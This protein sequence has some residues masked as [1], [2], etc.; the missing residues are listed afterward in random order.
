MDDSKLGQDNREAFRAWFRDRLSDDHF[1]NWESYRE[2]ARDN[3]VGVE[4][5][6]QK[7]KMLKKQLKKHHLLDLY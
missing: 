6:K 2:A 4:S 5:E 3:Q 7:I 1:H